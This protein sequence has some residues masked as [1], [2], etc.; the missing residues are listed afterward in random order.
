MHLLGLGL[1]NKNIFIH[2]LIKNVLL[3]RFA[4]IITVH[5]NDIND[6]KV[7]SKHIN[8]QFKNN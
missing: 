6:T 1:K 5:F 8:L 4:R 2:L 7:K 3:L